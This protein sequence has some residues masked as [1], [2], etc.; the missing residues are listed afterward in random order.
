L[1]VKK[2]PM[3]ITLGERE[4]QLLDRLAKDKML[5]KG[6]VIGHALR[7]LATLEDRLQAG[8]KVFLEDELK[9][10]SELMLL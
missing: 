1:P 5:S 8:A 6:N 3:T 2:I 7:V 9:N 4:A 10:K